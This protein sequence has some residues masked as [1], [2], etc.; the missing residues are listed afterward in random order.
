M[1]GTVVVEIRVDH[2]GFKYK[3][4]IAILER[5]HRK[6]VSL[7]TL[8]RLLRQQNLYRKGIQSPVPDIVSFIQH[9]LQGSGSCIGYC[10]MQQ[11]CIKNR[12]NVSRTIVAQVMKDLDPAGLDARRRRTLRRRLYYSK[13]PNWVWHLD[14]YDKLK[15]FGFEIHGCID[16]YSRRVLWLNI[17]RSNKDPKEVCN[18]FVNYLTVIKG[19]PRKLVADRGTENVFIAGS[20]RFLRRNHEDDLAGHL[21]FLFGKSIA[22]Q[23]IE[24]FWSQFRRSCAD[25]WIQFF[26]GPVHNGV[27]NNTDVLQVECFKFAFFPVIQKELENIKDNWNSHRIRKS[28]QSSNEGRPAGRPDILYFVGESSSEY[29]LKFNHDDLRLVKEECC[30]DER[31]TFWVCSN[32]FFELAAIVMEENGLFEANSPEEALLLFQELYQLILQI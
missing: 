32:E 27:Y 13:G 30:S 7:R 19:V 5:C 1:V 26:K 22:N 12:L 14:G 3:E 6:K 4:I 11:R 21:S 29:L 23:R 28:L 2:D 8:H 18:L 15:P 17:I 24:A 20:Q 10:A 31:N 25:W 16:E 9:E